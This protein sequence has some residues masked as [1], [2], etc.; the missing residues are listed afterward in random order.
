[1]FFP[2]LLFFDAIAVFVDVGSSSLTPATVQQ[3]TTTHENS[4]SAFDI[5]SKPGQVG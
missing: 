4:N 3:R 5:Q 2:T 1:M